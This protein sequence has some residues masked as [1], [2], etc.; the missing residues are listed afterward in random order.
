MVAAVTRVTAIVCGIVYL[1]A[2]PSLSEEDG[3]AA[4]VTLGDAIHQF[5]LGDTSSNTSVQSLGH[6]WPTRSLH[7]LLEMVGADF[8][9][10]L[11]MLSIS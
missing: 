9:D 3:R 6:C 7:D 5:L 4:I 8:G 11:Q 1:L 10:G 2:N